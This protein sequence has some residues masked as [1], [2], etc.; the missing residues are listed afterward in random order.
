MRKL[1][2][3]LAIGALLGAVPPA[4]AQSGD[5]L[6]LITSGAV[7]PFIGGGAIMPGSMSFLELASPVGE[8]DKLHAFFFDAACNKG[9]ISIPLDLT[10]NG[11]TV[12]RIDNRD[13][14]VQDGLIAVAKSPSGIAPFA[15]VDEPIHARVLWVN[16][17][18]NL[19]R[20]LEPIAVSNLDT[21]DTFSWNPLRSG[22]TFH[23]P[24]EGGGTSTLLLLVCPGSNV[25]GAFPT[26]EGF[27]AAPAVASFIDGI[28]YDTDENFLVNI[29]LTCKCLTATKVTA[30]APVYSD[31]SA[32]PNGTYTELYGEPSSSSPT[33]PSF[34]GYRSIR[35]SPTTPSFDLFGRLSNASACD[36]NPDIDPTGAGFCLD[37]NDNNR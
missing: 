13:P 19:G 28:I 32:A 6:G 36:L 37:S 1:I 23:A 34:T 25:T 14:A 10:T 8:N 11:L 18:Q 21:Q 27:P 17:A 31:A 30:I 33:R 4:M 24:L 35:V 7:L 2:V 9:T 5:A 22:A 12:Q 29:R 3:G 15:P 20:V 26:S 16:P